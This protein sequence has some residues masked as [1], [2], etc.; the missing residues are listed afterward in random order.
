MGNISY[1]YTTLIE[2]NIPKKNPNN[3]LKKRSVSKFYEKADKKDEINIPAAEY[4]IGCFLE[5]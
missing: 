1:I 5:L 4:I 2:I 3:V